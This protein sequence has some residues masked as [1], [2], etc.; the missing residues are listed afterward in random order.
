MTRAHGGL[1][2]GSSIVRHLIEM[3]GGKVRVESEGLGC[4]S[5]FIVSLP[6]RSVAEVAVEK[7]APEETAEGSGALKGLKI[8]VVDDESEARGLVGTIL[9][10]H[11]AQTQLAA[12]TKEAWAQLEE[13]QP[14]V[15]VSDIGMPRENGY[16]LLERAR[17]ASSPFQRIPA[18][19]LTAYASAT[20]RDRA[21]NAGFDAHLAKPVMPDTLLREVARLTGREK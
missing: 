7:N 2:L 16:Q 6:L 19:T 20:D 14:D 17:Q 5:K 8:L 21:Q 11:G 12:S 10:L 18:L 9:G 4:G 1:G 3:H 15:L 13:W